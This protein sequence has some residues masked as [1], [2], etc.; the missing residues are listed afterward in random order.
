MK[1]LLAWRVSWTFLF[2]RQRRHLGLENTFERFLL[3][4]ANPWSQVGVASHGVWR[5][6]KVW[7]VSW[8]REQWREEKHT[9]K[10]WCLVPCFYVS[11]SW[12]AWL[13]IGVWRITQ[14]RRRRRRG[15][16]WQKEL[17]IWGIYRLLIP[18][19]EA[20]EAGRGWEGGKKKGEAFNYSSISTHGISL[21]LIQVLV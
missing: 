14:R 13:V 8:R 18:R 15:C 1:E 19:V 11:V 6:S 21:Q 17:N 12:V 16:V 5:H 20:N 7:W 2:L 4:K 9:G 10:T 3:C